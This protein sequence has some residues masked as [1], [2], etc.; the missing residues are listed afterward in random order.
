MKLFIATIIALL[1]AHVSA[2]EATPPPNRQLPVLNPSLGIVQA[3]EVAAEVAAT[4]DT[5]PVF[6]PKPVP[7]NRKVPVISKADIV[8]AAT[9]KVGIL[10]NAL[11]HDLAVDLERLINNIPSESKRSIGVS[12]S[13]LP[14]EGQQA[15]QAAVELASDFSE[16]ASP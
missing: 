7:P 8:M 9:D 6:K 1:L 15:L 14:M 11:A 3:A 13:K 5:T 10:V 2:Q 16:S 4:P 12:E